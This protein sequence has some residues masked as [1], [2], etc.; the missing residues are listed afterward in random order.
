MEV[1]DEH[2]GVFQ[3]ADATGVERV[4]RPFAWVRFVYGNDGYD[5]ISDYTTSLEA[6]LAPINDWCSE[7]F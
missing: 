4:C 7:Q 1:D 5:V 3:A 2:L 6:V